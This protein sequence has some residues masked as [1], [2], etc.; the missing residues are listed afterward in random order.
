MAAVIASLGQTTT[1]TAATITNTTAKVP[2]R[3]MSMAAT[4]MA[5]PVKVNLLL[6]GCP[7]GTQVR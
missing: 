6:T 2:L 5:H 7:W 4:T 3:T 1:T